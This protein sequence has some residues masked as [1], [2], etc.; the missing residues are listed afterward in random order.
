MLRLSTHRALCQHWNFPASLP[1][2]RPSPPIGARTRYQ[3]RQLR[4]LL[5][6]PQALAHELDQERILLFLPV[7]EFGTPAVSLELLVLV[8]WQQGPKAVVPT[9]IELG[10]ELDGFG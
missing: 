5:V 2:S 8:D 3:R 9:S 1:R 10:D 7:G 6:L 4:I